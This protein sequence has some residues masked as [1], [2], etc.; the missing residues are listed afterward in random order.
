MNRATGAFDVLVVENEVALRD[1]LAKIL[2]H[3]GFSVRVAADGVEALSM[4]LGAELPRLIVLDLAMPRLGGEEFLELCRRN[5]RL[6][7]IPVVVVT[8]SM[9][10]G[11]LERMEVADVVSKPPS[12]KVF[13]DTVRKHC[14]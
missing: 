13:L 5:P 4:L 10:P 12:L 11:L 9:R 2:A 8:G 3:E 7:P 6:E 14:P 1:V